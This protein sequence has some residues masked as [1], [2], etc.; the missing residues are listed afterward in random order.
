MASNDAMPGGRRTI[1]A[2]SARTPCA[3][4]SK[5][6]MLQDSMP[7]K[8]TAI[9]DRRTSTSAIAGRFAGGWSRQPASSRAVR[10]RPISARARARFSGGRSNP[11]SGSISA[12]VPRPKAIQGPNMASSP[13]RSRNSCPRP[14]WR[15]TRKPVSRASGRAAAT[16]AA[17]SSAARRTAAA[18][19]RPRATPP[20]S[21]LRGRSGLKIFRTMGNPSMTAASAAS[22]GPPT[23]RPG[24][25][26]TP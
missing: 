20:T 5:G 15:C 2:S 3:S 13:R 22:S 1:A 26:G 11:S 9:C 12:A 24:T 6:L 17:I 7:G 14:A 16:R 19:I 23:A 21:V 10:V 25:V 4:A 18:V 8:S